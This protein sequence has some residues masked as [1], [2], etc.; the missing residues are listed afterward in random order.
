MKPLTVIKKHNKMIRFDKYNQHNNSIEDID[1]RRLINNTYSAN[2]IHFRNETICK[3]TKVIM[4]TLN[5]KLI[6]MNQ[7][8]QRI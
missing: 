7:Y 4:Q 6:K 8:S 2:G 5:E 3:S 1:I